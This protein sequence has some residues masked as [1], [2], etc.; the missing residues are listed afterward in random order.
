MRRRGAWPRSASALHLNLVSPNCYTI[1][2]TLFL[3]LL[4][5]ESRS[6]EFEAASQLIDPSPRARNTF[7]S[8]SL[9]RPHSRRSKRRVHHGC[10]AVLR[11][12]QRRPSSAPHHVQ[13]GCHDQIKKTPLS[14]GLT[15]QGQHRAS[16]QSPSTASMP[17][18]DRSSGFPPVGWW[19][20]AP[21]TRALP[22][23]CP[24]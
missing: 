16:I 19:P 24:R 8:L 11:R 10:G 21:A 2:E 1:Q 13:L 12:R 7:L 20:V 15:S 9:A 5:R 3:R 18:R 17:A 23:A 22:C 4:F 6:L 14:A